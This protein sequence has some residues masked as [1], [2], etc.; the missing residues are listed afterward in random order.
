MRWLQ[1]II[2]I[3]N[4]II[5][6][7]SASSPSSSEQTYPLTWRHIHERALT[8]E[9]EGV[10]SVPDQNPHVLYLVSSKRFC[11]NL[12]FLQCEQITAKRNFFLYLHQAFS[13]T[14]GYTKLSFKCVQINYIDTR[15]L[16]SGTKQKWYM[17]GCA[18]F[19]MLNRLLNNSCRS[20]GSWSYWRRNCRVTVQSQW[21]H[22]SFCLFQ[23]LDYGDWIFLSLFLLAAL[24]NRS[25]VKWRIKYKLL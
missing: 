15:T 9:I 24:N 6:N 12:K 17:F 21:I 1:N 23:V 3:V 25:Q 19:V 14:S 10:D 22:Q 20:T 13:D 2:H 18:C 7:A 5:P 16:M 11:Q 4:L 8:K